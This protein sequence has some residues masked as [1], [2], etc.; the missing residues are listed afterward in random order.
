MP[1]SLFLQHSDQ[2]F[3]TDSPSNGFEEEEG[4]QKGNDYGVFDLVHHGLNVGGHVLNHG[5]NVGGDVLK[6]S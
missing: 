1:V 3:L 4:L 2:F 6:V 5:L